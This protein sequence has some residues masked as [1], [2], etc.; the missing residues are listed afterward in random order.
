MNPITL[1]CRLGCMVLLLVA[2]YMG[3][4]AW[5]AFGDPLI[6]TVMAIAATCVTFCAHDLW[7]LPRHFE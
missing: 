7:R 5:A 4:C 2:I 3:C 1:V 6:S